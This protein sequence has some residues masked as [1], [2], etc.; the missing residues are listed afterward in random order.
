MND[1]FVA[2]EETPLLVWNGGGGHDV[3]ETCTI[4]R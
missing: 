1:L 4:F 2:C 3:R